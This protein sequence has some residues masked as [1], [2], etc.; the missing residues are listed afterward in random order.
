MADALRVQPGLRVEIDPAPPWPCVLGRVHLGVFDRTPAPVVSPDGACRLVVAGEVRQHPRGAPALLD[1][2]LARGDAALAGL[3]GSFVLALWDGRARRLVVANDRFGLRNCF[4]VALEGGV[5]FAPGVAALLAAVGGSRALDADAAVEL[6]TFQCI[7]GD[8]TLVRGIRL[9]P[10]AALLTLEAG[11]P[12]RIERTWRL[13]YRPEP[14]GCDRHAA[15]L[16]DALR[17]TVARHVAAPGRV[18][19]PLSGGLDSRTLLAALPHAAA[20]PT[21]TYGRRGSDDVARATELAALAGT[22]QHELPL[23]PG[24]A[25]RLAAT[26]VAVTDG[27]H[28]CLNA[29]AAVLA[30]AA[31][32]CDVLLLGNGGDCLL[33]GLWDG[34][35]A[36]TDAAVAERLVPRLTIGVPPALAARLAAPGSPFAEAG[37]RA[38]Q[39]FRALLATC[40]GDHPADRADAFNVVHRH[41]RWVLQG[42]RAQAPWVEFRHPYYDDAVVEAALGVPPALRRHRRAHAAA[43]ARLSPVLARVPRDGASLGFAAPEWRWRVHRARDRVRGAIRWRANRLGLNRRLAR[44]NRRA[45]ADYD[46]ELRA[47]SR[48]LLERV[49]LGPAS[50]ARGWWRPEALR[51]AV[52]EHLAGRANHA[53]ALG[54]LITLELFAQATFDG[55]TPVACLALETRARA[56]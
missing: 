45:F 28:S 54:M 13:A 4:W 17:E 12:P 56:S 7:L 20:V 44:P 18:G 29:H 21:I 11:A 24:Y 25:A 42:V 9:L 3:S 35:R 30:R 5:A 48:A 43:L 36:A 46:E 50:L 32:V 33:D 49:L 10:P 14:G 55:V 40:P 34:G 31:E 53:A 26:M 15:R 52:A 6:L 1:A 41:R 22:T 38:A 8:R 19:L 16:A 23:L 37:P 47:G 51:A 27:M 2:Y 39:A